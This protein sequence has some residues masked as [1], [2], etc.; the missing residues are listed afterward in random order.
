MNKIST[1]VVILM[2]FLN[3]SLVFAKDKYIGTGHVQFDDVDIDIFTEGYLKLP[4]GKSPA[5]FWIAVEDGKTIWSTYWWCPNS[6]CG[7]TWSSNQKDKLTCERAGREYY[8]KEMKTKVDIECFIF[9]KR[10]E[11]VWDNGNKPE[12]WKQSVIKSSLSKSQIKNKFNELGFYGNGK[13]TEE[14]KPKITK[15]KDSSEIKAKSDKKVS[16][17]VVEEL[18]ELNDL[19]KTGAITKEEFD[20]AKKKILN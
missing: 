6:S 17:D 20:K 7:N 5:V 15:K 3:P 8:K 13:K 16:N 18:K 2:F 11:I 4:A 19:Y 12:N 10:Y 1:L 14:V 9:A